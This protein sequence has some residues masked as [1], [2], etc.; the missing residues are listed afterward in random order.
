MQTYKVIG[1]MSGTSLD[2]LDIAFCTFKLSD[3]QWEYSI[4]G[5]TT[6]GY[7]P[8]LTERLANAESGTA[9]ELAQLNIDFGHLIGQEVH[10]FAQMEGF[11]ADFIASHGHTIFHQTEKKLT[12]QIGSGAA[13]A[14]ETQLPVVCDFRTV[15]VALGGQ[16]APLVP[17]GDRLLFGNYDY[18]LNLGGIANISFEAFGERIAFDICPINMALNPIARQLGHVY[19]PNGSIARSG[20]LNNAL[21]AELNSLAFYGEAGPKSLGKEWYLEVFL[22]VVESY[23]IP[24]ADKLRTICEHAAQ[25]I[26]TISGSTRGKRALVTGG[27]ANNTFFIECLNRLAPSQF[28]IGTPGLI[29]FKEALIFAFLGV[30]RMRNEANCLSTVTGA[31][32]DNIGGA[33]YRALN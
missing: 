29:D 4:E 32:H 24:P 6:I 9:L 25:Q 19:D 17:I 14:A 16:G 21:L 31:S 26:V 20:S 7:T 22:P 18:C 2:G 10:N 11:E 33:I 5:G 15:D 8:D 27:G 23:N 1:T 3:S 12:L 28:E 13:I 30:L